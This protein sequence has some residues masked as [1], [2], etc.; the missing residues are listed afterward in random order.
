MSLINLKPAS[1]KVVFVCVFTFLMFFP[2]IPKLIALFVALIKGEPIIPSILF[3]LLLV[4]GIGTA[5]L[6]AGGVSLF[7]YEIFFNKTNKLNL[8][9][10]VGIFSMA[11]FISILIKFP[12]DYAHFFALFVL[13][14][15]NTLLILRFSVWLHVEQKLSKPL[16]LTYASIMFFCNY[17]GFLGFLNR[18]SYWEG[19]DAAAFG[20][21]VIF[22]TPIAIILCFSY[23]IYIDRKRSK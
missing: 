18:F 10:L 19:E 22:F 11:T 5:G 7:F 6:L 8:N 1:I 13:P 4:F 3:I 12:E 17:G 21:P 15:T 16:T 14:I 9:L 23:L 2:V 20:I